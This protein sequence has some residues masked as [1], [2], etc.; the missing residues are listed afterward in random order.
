MTGSRNNK[1][2]EAYKIKRE[3]AMKAF[4]LG[5]V[6]F[7]HDTKKVYTPREFM[8]SDEVVSVQKLG[9]QDYNNFTLHYAKYAI[10]KKLEELRHAQEEFD[11]FMLKM[12]DAFQLNPQQTKNKK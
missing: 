8:E 1:D 11:K 10:A 9:M 3:I 12:L 4:N 7:S 6:I 5:C 2:S